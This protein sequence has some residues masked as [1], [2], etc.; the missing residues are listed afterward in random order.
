MKNENTGGTAAER[1]FLTV[2]EVAADILN[3]STRTVWRLV[4]AGH[5]PKP[6][7]VGPRLKRWHRPTLEQWIIDGASR[8]GGPRR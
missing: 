6:V 2:E 1:P 3:T 8:C 4:D 7:S 5:L